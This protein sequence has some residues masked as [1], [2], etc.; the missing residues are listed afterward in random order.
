MQ[1]AELS[2]LIDAHRAQVFGF[3]RARAK[4]DAIAHDL[5]Q[6]TWVEVVRRARTYDP[7]KGRFRTFV[8]IWAHFVW[9]RRLEEV[10]RD[11]LVLESELATDDTDERDDLYERSA[12]AALDIEE[13]LTLSQAYLEL[14]RYCASC[15]RP[16][17]EVIGFGFSRLECKPAALVAES[18]DLPLSAL[19][20]QLE[21]EYGELAPLP[22]LHAAFLPL[23]VRLA[24]ALSAVMRDPRTRELYAAI[25]DLARIAGDT[26][27]KDYYRPDRKPEGE[28][29][30][31]CDSV[32][33]AVLA[34]IQR[35]GR[36]IL[37]DLLRDGRTL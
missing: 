21:R 27:L 9:K 23:R 6:R 13:R 30:R 22:T 17:H 32:K 4:D 1:E 16:P 8:M 35:A 5:E 36:G 29:M 2:Q 31:W 20:A 7:Q 12:S 26:A 37:F 10:S 28:V 24:L 19:E 25:I 11:R 14:V 3:F 34:D 33:K 15:Q 18:S